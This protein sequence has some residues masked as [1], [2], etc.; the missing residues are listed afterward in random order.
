MSPI[1]RKA[2]TTAKTLITALFIM[3]EV[4]SEASTVTLYNYV[5]DYQINAT[6]VPATTGQ[7]LPSGVAAPTRDGYVFGGYFASNYGQGTQYYSDAMAPM[8]AW[9]V[10]GDGTIYAHWTIPGTSI[11]IFNNGSDATGGQTAPMLMEYGALLPVLDTS[12]APTRAHHQFAGYWDDPN[13]G[14]QYYLVNMKPVA[15][16]TWDKPADV[17]ELFARWTY[18][19]T[20]AIFLDVGG[21]VN[22]GATTINDAVLGQY[23]STAGLAVPVWTGFSFEGYYEQPGG[24]GAQYISKGLSTVG[25]AQWNQTGSGLHIYA[26]WI[27]RSTLDVYFNVTYS[28]NPPPYPSE[29]PKWVTY[30][31][32]YGTFPAILNMPA[33]ALL[34]GW[35]TSSSF[36]N[37]TRVTASS[38][39]NNANNHTLYALIVPT[40]DTVTITLDAGTNG[41]TVGNQPSITRVFPSNGNYT[42]GLLGF[43]DPNNRPGWQFNGWYTL[44]S[45]GVLIDNAT[46]VPNAN[47]TYYAQWSFIPF[48]DGFVDFD[49]V[50]VNDLGAVDPGVPVNIPLGEGTKP[51]GVQATY[52]VT[53][54]TLPLGVMI[55]PWTGTVYGTVAQDAP[56]GF[57]TFEVTLSAGYGAPEVMRPFLLAVGETHVVTLDAGVY[58]GVPGTPGTLD[59]PAI[60]GVL[61][62]SGATA[63][64]HPS[65]AV[66]AGFFYLPNGQG[67]Q[68]YAADM[69][70]VAAWHYS[71]TK[72]DVIIAH[73]LPV[74]SA[75]SEL[76][77]NNGIESQ[78]CW[79]K[80]SVVYGAPMPPIDALMTVPTR[81]G[82]TFAGYWSTPAYAHEYTPSIWWP[83]YGTMYY[84]TSLEPVVN[85]NWNYPVD[86]VVYLYA[87]WVAKQWANSNLWLD[88]NGGVDEAGWNGPQYLD[89]HHICYGEVIPSQTLTSFPLTLPT[90]TGHMFMGYFENPDGTGA[91]YLSWDGTTLGMDVWN[92]EWPSPANANWTIY[93][94]WKPI[95]VADEVNISFTNEGYGDPITARPRTVLVGRPY[96]RLPSYIG[97]GHFIGWFQTPDFQPGTFVTSDTLVPDIGDH[98]LYALIVPGYNQYGTVHFD[99]NGGTF[100]SSPNSIQRDYP[101]PGTYAVP[102]LPVPDFRLGHVFDGW[103]DASGNWVAESDPIPNNMDTYLAAQ[104]S[105]A[106]VTGSPWCDFTP[107]DQLSFN[108]LGVVYRGQTVNIPLGGAEAGGARLIY[109]N[110]GG[111]GVYAPNVQPFNLHVDPNIGELFG[112]VAF[113]EALGDYYF[114]VTLYVDNSVLSQMVTFKLTVADE[115]PPASNIRIT[116]IRVFEADVPH[117]GLVE[118]VEIEVEGCVNPVKWYNVFGH[119]EEISRDF[120]GGSLN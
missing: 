46:P 113:D 103:K 30:Q 72:P 98:M 63:P 41:G 109:I 26:Y 52:Q 51:V 73:W 74:G 101:F 58:G 32:A 2:L 106:P 61:L 108:D 99:P 84:D 36:A 28:A 86:G 22:P 115:P 7:P 94:H 96:G 77:F 90:R 95:S 5:Q 21:G 70:P 59:V 79:A 91:Q 11:A 93:A 10:N 100:K 53:S 20:G 8:A 67:T 9:G 49:P 45:G 118:R 12:V 111:G 105:P 68:Y 87:R 44:P 24:Q 114:T 89:G 85:L 39:V 23:L 48:Y 62:P 57:Y 83:N 43:P 66:F 65:G 13:A 60:S 97:Q 6:T 75:T 47:T 3:A 17:V 117:V 82:H 29:S 19:P 40:S 112:Q 55:D 1:R 76:R 64:T 50:D 31:A 27:T 102:G 81:A 92:Q 119:H 25:M 38:I 4:A 80:V 78:L 71:P 14:T 34:I 110:M 107:Y 35:F 33:D 120:G 69:T 42:I 56:L 16:K 18:N 37:G 116:A 104:W 15:N 88:F 54:G